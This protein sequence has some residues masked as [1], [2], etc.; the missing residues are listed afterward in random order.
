MRQ[1]DDRRLA[2]PLVHGQLC[3]VFPAR[4]E[5]DG[6]VHVS[7]RVAVNGE[8]R[9]LEQITRGMRR[10][11]LRRHLPAEMRLDGK[12]QIHDAHENPSGCVIP[13]GRLL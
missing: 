4:Q 3:D 12:G 13:S 7:E 10:A 9:Y 8:H 6:R 1:I 2:H 11:M 5:V